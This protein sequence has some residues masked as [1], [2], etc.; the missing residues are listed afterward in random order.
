M[1][2]MFLC[3][4]GD[5]VVPALLRAEQRKIIEI[6]YP[7]LLFLAR[8]ESLRTT[9]PRISS[10]GSGSNHIL[11]DPEVLPGMPCLSE[12]RNMRDQRRCQTGTGKSE[13]CGCPPVYGAGNEAIEDN[14]NVA[15]MLEGTYCFGREMADVKRLWIIA[16][17]FSLSGCG[18]AHSEAPV[19]PSA[20]PEEQSE[21][22]K[23]EGPMKSAGK[24]ACILIGEEPVVVRWQINKNVSF[25]KEHVKEEPLKV[26]LWNCGGFEQVGSPG[27]RVPERP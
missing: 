9:S 2:H 25:P 20:Q 23:E 7:D 11:R 13:E 8:G 26:Q 24:N 22:V 3:P 10:A 19:M 14:G 12:E 6:L 21:A 17:L 1:F 16:L 4:G 27:V 18:T 15:L 5:L